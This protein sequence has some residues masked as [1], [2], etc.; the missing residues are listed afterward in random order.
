MLAALQSATSAALY[1][2]SHLWTSIALFVGA[3]GTVVALRGIFAQLGF[4]RSQSITKIA[5]KTLEVRL[6]ELSKSMR[7]SARLVEQV[8]AELDARAVL[9][10]KLKE[11]ADAAEVLAGIHKE[12][13][14][15]IRRLMDAELEGTERHIRRDSI[16][17]GIGSFI[18]GGAVSLVITLLVHPLH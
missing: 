16:L 12:Q 13:V 15:A 11:E 14:E 10:K 1:T 8:S 7:D 17:I 18:A 3:L 5:E 9:A 6:E 4:T 2:S